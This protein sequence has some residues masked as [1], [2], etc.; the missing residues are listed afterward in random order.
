MC[1]LERLLS[2]EKLDIRHNQIHDAAEILRL[3][4][5]P[6]LT[7]L[8]IGEGNPFLDDLTSHRGHGWRVR[9]FDGYLRVPDKARRQ[10]V[11]L[12]RLDGSQPSWNEQRHLSHIHKYDER[13]VKEAA[14]LRETATWPSNS[15]MVPDLGVDSPVKTLQSRRSRNLS[16][17]AACRVDEVSLSPPLPPPMQESRDKNPADRVTGTQSSTSQAPANN[18]TVAKTV[19]RKHRR[20]IDLDRPEGTVLPEQDK[21]AERN[22]HRAQS[23]PAGTSRVSGQGE[24]THRDIHKKSTLSTKAAASKKVVNSRALKSNTFQDPALEAVQGSQTDSG[25]DAEDFRRKME[26][27]R[28]EVGATNWLSVYA[29]T[30]HARQAEGGSADA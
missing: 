4:T 28:N 2:L 16:E 10:L 17:N 18:S 24:D 7:D 22:R 6:H 1:G 19:K 14:S 25:S 30:V 12:P 3:V 5:L 11:E 13:K 23:V 26:K 21:A 27:L 29:N 20:I 8:W 15:R 9:F